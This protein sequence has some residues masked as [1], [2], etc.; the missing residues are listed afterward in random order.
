MEGREF[1]EEGGG[2]G[3]FLYDATPT[4]CLL[5]NDANRVVRAGEG[6]GGG[7][8]G[9]G[10]VTLVGSVAAVYVFV[11]FRMT[12]FVCHSDSL[13][14]LQLFS[15]PPPPSLPPPPP[16]SPASSGPPHPPPSPGLD[17]PV[18]KRRASSSPR[19]P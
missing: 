9:E 4:C 6:E 11:E 19:F 18:V 17:G 2:G 5:T 8:G 7:G 10:G 1:G 14:L 16:Q 15:P 12:L 13:S 3:N